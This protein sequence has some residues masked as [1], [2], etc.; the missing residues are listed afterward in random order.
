MIVSRRHLASY[1]ECGATLLVTLVLLI[2]LTM[3]A[4]SMI[5]SSN[6]NLKIVGNFQQQKIMEQGASDNLESFISSS[7]NFSETTAAPPAVC[8]N[9]LDSSCTGGYQVLIT[10]PSSTPSSETLATKCIKSSTATGYTKKIGELAPEDNDWE[11]QASVV[12][13]VDNS[14][15]Y[16]KIVEGVRVRM[17]AGNCP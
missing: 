11:V 8:V 10:V 9:G 5:S 3:F 17:L 4:I 7:G 1:H 6:L 14:K 12:D 2:V 15:V 13:P 16:M